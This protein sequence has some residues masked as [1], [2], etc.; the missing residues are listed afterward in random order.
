MKQVGNLAIVCAKRPDVLMQLY[1]GTA[2]VYFGQGP[3]KGSLSAK[4]DD[5]AAI[6]SIIH[7]L[8]FGKAAEQRKEHNAA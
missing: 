3:S 6:S 8:N 1:N 4:W 5:D 7:E 2:S